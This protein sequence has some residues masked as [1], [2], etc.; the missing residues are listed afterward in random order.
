MKGNDKNIKLGDA[1]VS[2]IIA[3]EIDGEVFPLLSKKYLKDLGIKG[4]SL[5]EVENQIKKIE[6]NILSLKEDLEKDKIYIQVNEEDPND[7]WN[8]L[9]EKIKSLK[10]GEKLKFIKYLLIRFPPPKMESQDQFIDYMKK[11]FTK[12]SDSEPFKE[13]EDNIDDFKELLSIDV[14]VDDL[15]QEKQEAIKLKII[16]EL[17]KKQIN[18]V[19]K[20]IPELPEDNK[21]IKD[22]IVFHDELNKENNYKIYSVIEQYKYKTSQNQHTYGLLNP[23]KEFER[24]ADDFQIRQINEKSWISF[25]EAFKIKVTSFSLWGS[26]EGLIKFWKEN[27]I[28]NAITYFEKNDKEAGIYLCINNSKKIAYLIIWPG[29]YSFQYSNIDEPNNN[30]LLS[31]VRYGFSLSNLSILSLSDN[32][33]D[34]FDFNFHKIFEKKSEMGCKRGKIEFD[35]NKEKKF[36]IKNGNG[37]ILNYKRN[38]IKNNKYII[39][40]KIRQNNIH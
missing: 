29:E 3:E 14:G 20:N 19:D 17:L 28:E 7:I 4:K 9:D 18:K 33:I 37:Q 24:L 34:N 5:N 35:E 6:K 21:E 40:S 16:I 39:E 2:N 1:F 22:E 36:E 25:R 27:N 38:D 8:T 15:L 31:L 32:E 11:V 23:I 26:K 30:L 13:I 10:I 12:K